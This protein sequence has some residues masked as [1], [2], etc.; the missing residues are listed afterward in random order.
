MK[1]E[2]TIREE[3]H[4]YDRWFESQVRKRLN[5]PEGPIYISELAAIDEF[6]AAEEKHFEDVKNLQYFTGLKKLDVGISIMHGDA[7]YLAGLTNLKELYI[8]LVSDGDFDYG[9]L[10]DLQNLEFLQV[11]S[12]WFWDVTHSNLSAL[13]SLKRLKELDI[14]EAKYV[15]VEAVCDIPEL[16][17][18]M[19]SFIHEAKNVDAVSRIPKLKYL[20]MCNVSVDNLD[21]LNGLDPSVEIK[22]CQ[23]DVKEPV[24]RKT[25]ERFPKR[26]ISEM[27]W[28]LVD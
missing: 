23:L 4:F 20:D 28:T 14:T 2:T 9:I 26:D 10:A 7:R 11:D 21:F 1:P 6:D 25:I 19:L 18:F 13:R 3:A 12:F 5:K 15:D 16:E 8:C 22:L 17:Y 27:Y 24:N